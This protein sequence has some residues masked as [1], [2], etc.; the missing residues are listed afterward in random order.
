[1]S[2]CKS[3]ISALERYELSYVLI[4]THMDAYRPICTYLDL[5][6]D[7]ICMI[8]DFQIAQSMRVNEETGN[9]LYKHVE[10]RSFFYS[11]SS[12]ITNYICLSVFKNS[13]GFNI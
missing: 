4:Y 2:H 13:L 5:Q 11:I 8:F 10:F 1:M 9:P 12:K 7:E 6:W 3:K